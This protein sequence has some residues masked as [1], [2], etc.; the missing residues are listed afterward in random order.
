[1]KVLFLTHRLPYAANR[2]DRLRALHILHALAGHVEVDLVS[3]V[4]SE[5]EA[6]HAADLRHLAASVTVAPISRLAGVGRAAV[7]LLTDRPFT[8]AMLF[9]REVGA[10]CRRIVSQRRPDV[11]LA[12]C[13]GMARFALEPPL[14]SI[15]LVLDMLDVDS[16]K[17]RALGSSAAAPTRWIYASEARRLSVFE[18]RAARAAHT[19]MVVNDRERDALLHLAP[20][21]RV[22]VVPNGVDATAFRPAAGPSTDRRVTFCGVMNYRPNEEGAAWF[23]REV[24]PMVRARNPHAM[25]SLVGSDPSPAIQRLAVADPSIEVTGSVPDTRPYLWRSAVGIAP[26]LVA[27]GVQN[28]VLE[29]VS[30]GLPCVVTPAVHEGLPAEIL[31]A[32]VVAPDAA[33]FASAVLHLLD[34]LPAERRAMAER[35]SLAPLA[36]SGR[37]AS[38]L[39]ILEAAARRAPLSAISR[40]DVA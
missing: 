15:P 39:G 38:L 9:A 27:R 6:R 17:W 26:L 34:C 40:A 36:W 1:M 24:W 31:P 13:S 7:A 25:L 20:T 33:R 12:Y 10:A 30:A 23:V 11:V 14:D 5:D 3:L 2:G 37:L 8:H 21:A 35:A 16:E 22:F 28:K 29:A 32:C 19:V 18:G 4:H